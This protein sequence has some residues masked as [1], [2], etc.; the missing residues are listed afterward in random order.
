M[1]LV[2]R[3]KIIFFYI[4]YKGVVSRNRIYLMIQKEFPEIGAVFAEGIDERC[5]W[6]HRRVIDHF[7][8]SEHCA[9]NPYKNIEWIVMTVILFLLAVTETQVTVHSW[10]VQFNLG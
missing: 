3:K 10:A 2:K 4:I 5:D 1:F 8:N 6:M 7:R 9:S